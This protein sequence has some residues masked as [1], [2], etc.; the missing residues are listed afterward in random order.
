MNK[1][2]GLGEPPKLSFYDLCKIYKLDYDDLLR[3]ASNADVIKKVIE[4]MYIG[5]LVKRSDAVAVL[6]AFSKMIGATWTLENVSVDVLP[7]PETR[8]SFLNLW[9]T[10]LFQI[11]KLASLSGVSEKVIDDMVC[12][13]PVRRDD[14]LK[15]L[16]TVSAITYLNYTLET[17]Y[18]LVINEDASHE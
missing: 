7:E 17:V 10:H 11:E 13:V 1:L 4:D 9:E 14:V 6:V 2:N 8:P 12:C 16:K 18:V 15:V 5:Y 3:I